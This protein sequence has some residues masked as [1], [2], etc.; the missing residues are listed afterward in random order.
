MALAHVALVSCV[1]AL[2]EVTQG[3]MLISYGDFSFY[4]AGLLV[5]HALYLL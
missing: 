3:R 5:A 4:D 1:Y 2:W